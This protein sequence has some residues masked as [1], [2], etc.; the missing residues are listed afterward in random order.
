VDVG[1]F[2]D[3]FRQRYQLDNL[4]G[5]SA[6]MRELLTKLVRVAPTTSPC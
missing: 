2:S 1:L 6:P 3:E 4:V 5:R